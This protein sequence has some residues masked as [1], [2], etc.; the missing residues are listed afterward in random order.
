MF[1][2]PPPG[3]TRAGGSRPAAPPCQTGW[4]SHRDLARRL[5]QEAGSTASES[6]RSRYFHLAGNNY[7][8]AAALARYDLQHLL[9]TAA[10][11]CYSAALAQR[12]AV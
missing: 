2:E 6:Q 4:Q 9:A 3:P 7:S 11:R 10:A 5:E 1:D 12:E 8:R